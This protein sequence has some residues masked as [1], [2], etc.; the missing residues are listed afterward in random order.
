MC[1]TV[2][3]SDGNNYFRLKY[4]KQKSRSYLKLRLKQKNNIFTSQESSCEFE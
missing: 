2:K 4:V 3:P 1:K